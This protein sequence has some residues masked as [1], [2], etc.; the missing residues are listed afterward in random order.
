MEGCPYT[1]RSEVF[2]FG[3]LLLV[4]LTGLHASARPPEQP[5]AAVYTLRRLLT[6]ERGELKPDFAALLLQCIRQSGVEVDEGVLELLLRLALQCV[7]SEPE[8]RPASMG[9]VLRA[10]CEAQS[11]QEDLPTPRELLRQLR[12]KVLPRLC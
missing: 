3:T 12:E 7:Q 1:A 11:K 9:E 5:R 8:D 4:M 10:L 6:N 2:S